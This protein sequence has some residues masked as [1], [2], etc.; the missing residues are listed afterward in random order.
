MHQDR[1]HYFLKACNGY[2]DFDN[3]PVSDFK[4]SVFRFKE[5]MMVTNIE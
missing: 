1:N 4:L 5:I 2:K 3:K